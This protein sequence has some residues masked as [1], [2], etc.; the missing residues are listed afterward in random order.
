MIRNLV[1]A[2][3][4]VR[5][6]RRRSAHRY[7]RRL[8]LDQLETR[9]MLAANVVGDFNADGRDDLAIG[10][11]EDG[12]GAVNVIYGS[13]A[14]LAS[15][16]NQRW[17]QN[18]S[19]ILDVAEEVDGFGS[20]LAVGDFNADGFD[21]LAVG[22]SGESL[23]D[24]QRAGAVNV[25]YGSQSG[26]QSAGNQF[27]NQNTS[28][29]LNEA[30]SG[31]FEDGE[32]FGAALAAGDFNHD[33]T[34]DLAIGVPQE[35]SENP[36]GGA[37][38]VIFGLSTVGLT[39]TNNQFWTQ[40]SSGILGQT[41]TEWFFGSALAS[42]DFDGDTQDDLAIGVPGYSIGEA[43]EAGAV[44]IIYGNGSAGLTSARNQLFTQ[45]SSGV[46]DVSEE[47]DSFGFSL[48][49][50]NFNADAFDDLAIGVYRE[51]IGTAADAGAINVLYGGNRVFEMGSAGATV[52]GLTAAGNQFWNQDSTGIQDTAESNQNPGSFDFGDNFGAAVAA[53]DLNGD[54]IDD[55]AI[56]VPG[57]SQ[58]SVLA[59]GIVQIILGSVSGLT[60]SGNQLW[61]QNTSGILD[62]AETGDAFGSTVCIGDFNGD[63]RPDLATSAPTES[64][65]LDPQVGA[66]HVIY[67]SL[68][69][70]TSA[71][72]QLWHQNTSGILGEA[73][74]N[75]F[76]GRALPGSTNLTFFGFNPGA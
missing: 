43:F 68:T 54:T 13:G 14:G 59:M 26:L 71:G 37:V 60:S 18:S 66:V 58:G 8:I 21:D 33:G 73:E 76:F 4:S 45:D 48:A 56:G 25:I 7:S 15:P 17:T 35:D 24:V 49:A 1:N 50:G 61:S 46:L 32:R 65:G 19:G 69:G 2:W 31:F 42:G 3:K 64:V 57:E 5:S 23:G 75:E 52:F 63:L 12:S 55:L 44:N 30:S 40:N 11:S 74:A 41:G 47:F 39:S 29:I 36:Y 22:V 28:G 9:A 67:N 20:A 27:W 72:N 70:L 38:H 6:N 53:G 34:D 51:D 62:A 10:V 16:G